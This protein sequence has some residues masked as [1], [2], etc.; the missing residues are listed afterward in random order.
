MA[1][2]TTF[3]ARGTPLYTHECPGCGSP[4]SLRQEAIGEALLKLA[5]ATSSDADIDGDLVPRYCLACLE[6]VLDEPG[7]LAR[8]EALITGLDA[9][10]P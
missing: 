7:E 10:L 8:L 3:P 2:T 9:L 1:T 6:S 4:V 5:A